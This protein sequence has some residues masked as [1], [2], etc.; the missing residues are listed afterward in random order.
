MFPLSATARV[1]PAL[2]EFKAQ[3]AALRPEPRRNPGEGLKLLEAVRRELSDPNEVENSVALQDQSMGLPFFDLIF[4]PLQ[5]QPTRGYFLRVV[6]AQAIRDKLIP[7]D[8]AFGNAVK[9]FETRSIRR[10]FV[11]INLGGSR[12]RFTPKRQDVALQVIGEC[13]LTEFV[14]LG[15]G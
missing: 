4:A 3:A 15:E 1:P 12:S 2:A 9:Q 13:S 10:H 11:E 8:F 7:T 6:L 5:F 14:G